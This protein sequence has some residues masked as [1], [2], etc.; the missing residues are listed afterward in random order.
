MHWLIHFSAYRNE[1]HCNVY[2]YC[3]VY[4]NSEC[5]GESAQANTII[6]ATISALNQCVKIPQRIVIKFLTKTFAS[7]PRKKI[8]SGYRVWHVISWDYDD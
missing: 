1:E 6:C 4:M 5:C 7:L 3:T 2:E 8:E